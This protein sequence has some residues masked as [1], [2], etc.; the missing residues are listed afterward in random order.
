MLRSAASTLRI[1]VAP[2]ITDT[3]NPFD[4]NMLFA[5]WYCC[6]CFAAFPFRSLSLTLRIELQ[7]WETSKLF[8]VLPKECFLIVLSV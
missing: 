3:Q 2:L 8:E 7:F 4:P 1:A 5:S 6:A